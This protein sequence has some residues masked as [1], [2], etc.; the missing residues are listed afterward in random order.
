MLKLRSISI[1]DYSVL[2]GHQRIGRIRFASRVVAA[3]H[4]MA[5]RPIR[6]YTALWGRVPRSFCINFAAQHYTPTS[7]RFRMAFGVRV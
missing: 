2:E 6:V 7:L 5:T 3:V 4:S 1:R